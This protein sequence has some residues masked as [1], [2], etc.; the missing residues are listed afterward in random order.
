MGVL[1]IINTKT[2]LPSVYDRWKSYY[3]NYMLKNFTKLYDFPYISKKLSEKRNQNDWR[4]KIN[5]HIVDKTLANKARNNQGGVIRST[6]NPNLSQREAKILM[7]IEGDAAARYA[8]SETFDSTSDRFIKHYSNI[9]SQTKGVNK[10]N[11]QNAQLREMSDDLKGVEKLNELSIEPYTLKTIN[12]KIDSRLEKMTSKNPNLN[13]EETRSELFK[14]EIH[15]LSNAYRKKRINL[16]S[17]AL[18]RSTVNSEP[19]NRHGKSPL[20]LYQGIGNL[21]HLPVDSTHSGLEKRAGNAID[22]RELKDTID[23]LRTVYGEGVHFQ[24]NKEKILK[25]VTDL[26][27]EKA[28]LLAELTMDRDKVTPVDIAELDL[29]QEELKKM[30]ETM[31][32]LENMGYKPNDL[33]ATMKEQLS[34]YHAPHKGFV[35]NKDYKD[36]H[37]NQLQEIMRADV[38]ETLGANLDS[39]NK[40]EHLEGW[41]RHPELYKTNPQR[42]IDLHNY[43][44]LEFDRSAFKNIFPNLTGKESAEVGDIMTKIAED[45][46]LSNMTDTIEYVR[47][48]PNEFLTELKLEYPSH[49]FN[50]E[51]P[52]SLGK[53]FNPNSFGGERVAGYPNAIAKRFGYNKASEQSIKRNSLGDIYDSIVNNKNKD[54]ER[55]LMDLQELRSIKGRDTHIYDNKAEIMNEISARLGKDHRSL[56]DIERITK[57]R[58]FITPNDLAKANLTGDELISLPL[59]RDSM[60]IMGY[61]VPTTETHAIKN[62][63]RDAFGSDLPG[64][65]S[66]PNLALDRYIDLDSQNFMREEHFK[67]LEPVMRGALEHHPDADFINASLDS[68]DKHKHLNALLENPEAYMT[69]PREVGAAK[70]EPYFRRPVLEDIFTSL[71]PHEVTEVGDVLHDMSGK[72]NMHDI[73]QLIN[74]VYNNPR[75]FAHELRTTYP[76]NSLS[77]Y[78][79]S[80]LARYFDPSQLNRGKKTIKSNQWKKVTYNPTP[81]QP[82]MVEDYAFTSPLPEHLSYGQINARSAEDSRFLGDFLD[83]VDVYHGVQEPEDVYEDAVDH[84]QVS[85]EVYEDAVDHGQVSEQAPEDARVPERPG[86]QPRSFT[87]RYN[88]FLGKVLKGFGKMSD[89]LFL[90]DAGK[91]GSEN[92]NTYK[93]NIKDK[94]WFSGAIHGVKD[95]MGRVYNYAAN[96]YNES[97]EGS[98][99]P[100]VNKVLPKAPMYNSEYVHPQIE[101]QSTGNPI[102]DVGQKITEIGDNTAQIFGLNEGEQPQEYKGPFMGLNPPP[103]TSSS[104]SISY[105][106]L[107]KQPSAQGAPSSSAPQKENITVNIRTSGEDT[108]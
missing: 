38:G 72:Y 59:T 91:I 66:S 12:E 85:E 4:D 94:G 98:F 95:A 61:E 14:K 69:N 15:K 46:G 63:F 57:G 99:V 80:S 58:D 90:I 103:L 70:K 5:K 102:T 77:N 22:I 52:Y 3:S 24:D 17:D 73:D 42:A 84:G 30:P 76:N 93:E 37:F 107:G 39:P 28:Q 54:P 81:L 83:D 33:F 41:L 21:I 105:P 26:K 100:Y 29:T 108:Y 2:K 64:S 16:D 6:D 62:M 79:D 40:I 11:A 74:H 31:R 10:L 65:L 32:E 36:H 71:D 92:T 49:S 104:D 89:A 88:N 87:G 55:Y 20:E 47:A 60:K 1:P 44:K 51:T 18:I 48:N 86:P 96:M 45:N 7:E 67:A 50:S 43:H 25:E 56:Q 35:I 101:N 27:P 13:I 8:Q 97:V 19:F 34:S 53:K 82:N 78:S 75:D 106:Q 68:P 9:D 23:E